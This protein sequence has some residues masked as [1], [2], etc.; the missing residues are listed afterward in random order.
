MSNFEAL[1]LLPELITAVEGMGWNLPRAVQDEAIP[2]ILGGGDVLIA[3][4]T[5]QGKTGAFC[6]PILQGLYEHLR[7]EADIT[8]RI[9]LQ[10]MAAKDSG[11]ADEAAAA[12]SVAAAGGQVPDA[13]AMAVLDRDP[14]CAVDRAG[15]LVQTRHPRDWGGVRAT[16]GVRPVAGARW[17]FEATV[18]DEGLARVGWTAGRAGTRNL[19]TDGSS[20][21]FGGTG[22]KSSQ[23]KFDDYGQKYGLNDTIGCLA[24]AA[25]DG[26]GAVQLSFTKNGTDLGV[27]FTV[28]AALAA[29]GL[30]PA[31]C[32]K[33]AEMRFTFGGEGSAPFKHCPQGARGVGTARAEERTSAQDEAPA[34]AA[35]ASAAGRKP[36]P[37]GNSPF[38]L[39]LEPTRELAQQV[40]D[41]LTKFAVNLHEPP[42]KHACFV[43]GV[44]ASDMARSIQRGLH[45]LV[46]T[47]ARI[48]ELV[49]SGKL[50]VSDTRCL[51]LDEADHLIS[52]AGGSKGDIL[53]LYNAMPKH[54]KGV[55]VVICSATLHSLDVQLLAEQLTVNATWVDLKGK[56][57]IPDTVD[58]V[59]VLADPRVDKRWQNAK[60]PAG[61][62]TDGVHANLRG[63][64]LRNADIESDADARSEALKVLKPL[65]LIDIIDQF[66][67]EQCMIFARTQVDCDAIEAFLIAAGGGQGAA[68]RG[69]FQ[70]RDTGP[71]N[72]YSCVVLHGGREAKER[73]A[74]LA[75]FKEGLVRF[76]ICTDVAAR[77]IDVRALPYVINVT[78]PSEAPTYIHRVGRVGRADHVGLAI[79]IVAAEGIQ[80][81]VWFHTCGTK[82]RGCNRTALVEQGGCTIW[83]DEPDMLEDV[84]KL[85]GGT[86]V[87][88]L[89]RE[90]LAMGADFVASL[91]SK[92]RRVVD[93][94]AAASGAH[95]AALKPTVE[96]LADLE[97]RAQQ[98]FWDT[99]R[100]NK[101]RDMLKG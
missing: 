56:D 22:K 44:S 94:G 12:A 39:I 52:D 67:M 76:L 30:Y 27:A 53:A 89:D 25:T 48:A 41:E 21:G 93:D 75:A 40:S 83:F 14:L 23:N 32:L 9:V 54:S 1:G 31:V 70:R 8:A 92:G 59:V 50:D 17:Y 81:R 43:G 72:K 74:N 86:Q 84:E 37:S 38:A 98:V 88:H 97:V 29:Q 2:L 57:S 49:R 16:R 42:V 101:W 87:P 100:E 3:A 26:S 66:K 6:L 60:L 63:D 82:G 85:L 28:P 20:F 7:G 90:R 96:Q 5:G 78:L 35:A 46:G 47:P 69:G 73:Q 45:I 91:A 77:G 19:G 80:E 51:V 79:S 15:L 4:E 61:L 71:E 58:H 95:V 99:K 62:R 55:Q 65:L 64:A 18:T 34:A 68:G 13:C 11:S 10:N 24:I 36:K 33:N